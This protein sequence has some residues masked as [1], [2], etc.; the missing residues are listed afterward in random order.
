LQ[1]ERE[2]TRE[3]RQAEQTQTREERRTDQSARLAARLA[4]RYGITVEQVQ[5]LADGACAGDWNCVQETLQA[6]YGNPRGGGQ[7]GKK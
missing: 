2:A 6:Q 4:Q 7:G 3:Q 1:Q 5:A